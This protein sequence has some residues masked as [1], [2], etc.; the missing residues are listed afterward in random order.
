MCSIHL[1]WSTK[2][3]QSD[4]FL[5]VDCEVGSS[6]LASGIRS[7]QNNSG[8]EWKRKSLGIRRPIPLCSQLSSSRIDI[9]KNCRK[10]RSSWGNTCDRHA[11]PFTSSDVM[12]REDALI[13]RKCTTSS[14]LSLPT[15]TPIDTWGEF[16]FR[17][18]TKL[19]IFSWVAVPLSSGKCLLI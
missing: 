13:T 14:T 6:F 9:H 15:F 2:S 8:L 3:F 18:Q 4:N 1:G 10:S 17:V 16:G 7:N 19:S 12:S 11:Y 5:F